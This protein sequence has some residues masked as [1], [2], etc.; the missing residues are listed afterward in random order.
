MN[1]HRQH[2]SKGGF[3][4]NKDGDRNR[5]DKRK[6]T[7][8]FTPRPTNWEASKK[9]WPSAHP[10]PQSYN[11]NIIPLPIRMGRHWINRID[12]LPAEADGNIE[13][14]KIPN[15]FH[16]TPPAIE[17]HCEALKPYTT[18]FPKDVIDRPI[19]ITTINYL[20]DGPSVR[21][22][23]S[24]KIKFQ[25]YVKDLQLTA[26]EET[27][28]KRLLGK[29]YNPQNDE[30]TLISQLCTT[31]AHNKEYGYYLLASL[32]QEA[33]TVHDWEEKV[34][35]YQDEVVDVE[36]SSVRK[37][38]KPKLNTKTKYKK[39]EWHRIVGD[40][41]V[42]YN[43]V[44]YPFLVQIQKQRVRGMLPRE[45]VEEAKEVWKSIQKYIKDKSTFDPLVL[46]NRI[47]SA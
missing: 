38:L 22:P 20:Y 18:P 28:L 25:V 26:V 30:L 16:L 40:K 6:K 31:R 11:Q 45:H 19:R 17:R 2:K 15:F 34:S 23:N 13:L 36:L 4:G 37:E 27:K 1:N 9:D 44:G 33:R 12:P 7:N 5:G 10:T 39:K 35:E 21:H 14:L 41:L 24:R 42:K 46:K 47:D 29:R 8:L 32:L 3:F 43:D